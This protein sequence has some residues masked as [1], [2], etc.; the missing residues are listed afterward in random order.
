MDTIVK[1]EE[2]KYFK[3]IE[4][5]L[6]IRKSIDDQ[7]T[8]ILYN[9]ISNFKVN[10]DNFKIVVMDIPKYKSPYTDYINDYRDEY[11]KYLQNLYPENYKLDAGFSAMIDA[12]RSKN[13]NLVMIYKNFSLIG[14]A[15]YDIIDKK[16]NIDVNHIGV[17][18]RQHG[19]GTFIMREIFSFAKIV[20]YSVTV[21]SSGGDSD[22]FY[23]SL[24]MIRIADKPL[25]I[26]HIKSQ[27][28]GV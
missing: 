18:E 10:N 13:E 2:V 16:K 15:S 9:R 23:H 3:W 8:Y 26:Y 12:I 22:D 11:V 25:G 24:G 14:A 21:T 5:A 27:Y 19:Y 7:T 1:P 6:I 4:P 17:M 28:I 20:E